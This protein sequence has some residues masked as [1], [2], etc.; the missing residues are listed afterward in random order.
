MKATIRKTTPAQN[1]LPVRS[2][3]TIAIM[4]AGR[5]KRRTL[6]ITTIMIRPTT[7]RNSSTITSNSS[8][9]PRI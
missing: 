9:K 6:A 1:K 3:T 8:G 2:Q 5:K 4:A 7:K